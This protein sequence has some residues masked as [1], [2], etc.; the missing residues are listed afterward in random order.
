MK[1]DMN[2]YAERFK[3]LGYYDKDMSNEDVIKELEAL[4]ERL[5]SCGAYEKDKD[6]LEIMD[7]LEDLAIE[8]QYPGF[9]NA[10]KEQIRMCNTAYNEGYEVGRKIG[11]AKSMLERD[12]DIETISKITGLS[13]DEVNDIKD[14]KE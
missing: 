5:K 12:I 6:I 3:N 10:E 1:I 7:E 9:Y 13:I 2:F 8:D 4:V 14:G 11:M